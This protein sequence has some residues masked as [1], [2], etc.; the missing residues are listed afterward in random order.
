MLIYE[1]YQLR[2]QPSSYT[3]ERVFYVSLIKSG[4]L[5]MKMNLINHLEKRDSFNI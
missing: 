3:K 1:S 2:Y 5:F 4:K